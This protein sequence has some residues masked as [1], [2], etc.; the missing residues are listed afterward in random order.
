M[1]KFTNRYIAGKNLAHT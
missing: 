1:F